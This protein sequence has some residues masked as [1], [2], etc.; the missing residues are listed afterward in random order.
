MA[1]TQA[2]EQDVFF[3]PGSQDVQRESRIHETKINQ[4]TWYTWMLALFASICPGSILQRLNSIHRCSSLADMFGFP[5]CDMCSRKRR[6]VD[7]WQHC[8]GLDFLPLSALLLQNP[9][10]LPL[11]LYS[12][13]AAPYLQ[14]PD[15]WKLFVFLSKAWGSED[16]VTENRDNLS[17][18]I[19]MLAH[20]SVVYKLFLIRLVMISDTLLEPDLTIQR[21]FLF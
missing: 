10:I 11:Y 17:N 2:V 6:A 21:T 16:T 4:D 3:E 5:W 15:R 20:W 14:A 12:T 18:P 9:S 1:A 19:E 7:H 8:L 13:L